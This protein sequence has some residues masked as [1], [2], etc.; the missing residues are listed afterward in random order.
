M[1]NLPSIMVKIKKNAREAKGVIEIKEGGNIQVR[2]TEL[3]NQPITNGPLIK[4][5]VCS[6]M[7]SNKI[8]IVR[9]D[10]V[11]VEIPE[12]DLTQ[13]RII[14]RLRAPNADTQPPIMPK[15]K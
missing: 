8:R 1:L 10:L 11:I 13:C 12:V 6:K 4:G 3:E 7:S 2:L 5:Y 9:G 14:S 15:K